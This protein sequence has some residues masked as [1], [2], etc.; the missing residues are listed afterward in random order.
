MPDRHG[1]SD[2]TAAIE[3]VEA[4]AVAGTA[5]LLRRRGSAGSP[6]AS[7]GAW[8]DG[9]EAGTAGEPL[10]PG[11]FEAEHEPAAWGPSSALHVRPSV[12][13]VA[14]VAALG[15]LVFGYDIGGSGGSFVM[16]GFRRHFGWPVPMPEGGREPEYVLREMALINALLPVGGLLGAAPSGLLADRL[17]RRP[18]IAIAALVFTVGAV[19]QARACANVAP[20]GEG[21]CMRVRGLR[22]LRV[23][24]ALQACAP[25]MAVLLA[26]RVVGGIGIGA[27]SAI[28]PVYIAELAPEHL[29]GALSTLWQLAVTVG[30]V[31]AGGLNVKL[32]SWEEGWRL[33]YSAN[34]AFSAAL[35]GLMVAAMPES[36]RWLCRAGRHDAARA[37]LA[38]L[39]WPHE[40]GPELEEVRAK[41]KEERAA[42][43]GGWGDLLRPDNCMRARTLLG[44]SLQFFQQFSGINAIM[45]FAPAMLARFFSAA[46]A[47]YGALAINVLNHAATYIT[48]AAVDRAGRVVL[49]VSSGAIMAAAH[50]AVAVLAAQ[51]P[52]PSTGYAIVALCCVFVVAFAYGWGPVTWT[53]CSEIFPLSLRGK[54]VSVSTAVNWAAAAAVG[55]LFPLLSAPNALDLWGT[56]ALFAAFCAAG[57]LNAQLCLPETAG[58]SLEDVDKLFAAHRPQLTRR[59]WA[60]MDD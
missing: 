29:R 51:P 10:S 49:M 6:P 39:R 1:E 5:E 54:G 47:L 55:L 37:A 20:T 8:R 41:A 38:R 22:L 7:P 11:G 60:L 59:F 33:S 57:T 15:G 45:F 21:G 56:F 24:V 3:L 36:P 48:L 43:E 23:V 19:M 34:A 50:L 28:V 58:A 31:L 27:L 44:M 2:D 4:P 40:V 9:D 16:A 14:L 32:A 13:L 35:A 12:Y 18:T 46:G 26:G 53:L 17:G 30:I 25:S 42:G 52:A